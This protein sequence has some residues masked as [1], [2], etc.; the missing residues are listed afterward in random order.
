MVGSYD[1]HIFATDDV[2][3]M[4][5]HYY[6]LAITI[7]AGPCENT[8]LDMTSIRDMTTQVDQ[9]ADTQTMQ[10]PDSVS[11]AQGS[12]DGQAYCG[13]RTFS[14]TSEA[15]PM[16]VLSGGNVLTLSTSDPL[17]AGTF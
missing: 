2:D 16:L 6:T 13:P 3:P 17:T 4:L 5:K 10:V 9:A 15:S 7:V 14:V 11:I 12:A 8:N 1:F